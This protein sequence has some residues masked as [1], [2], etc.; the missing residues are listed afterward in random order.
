MLAESASV[1]GARHQGF[2]QGLEESQASGCEEDSSSASVRCHQVAI[3]VGA[4]RTLS[5]ALGL[6]LCWT[7]RGWAQGLNLDRGFQQK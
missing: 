2:L 4:Q 1:T 7:R 3:A 6:S 5:P